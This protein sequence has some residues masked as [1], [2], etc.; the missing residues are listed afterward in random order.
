M[1]FTPE[2]RPTTTRIAVAGGALLAVTAVAVGGVLASNSH[3]SA[4]AAETPTEV[5]AEVAASPSATPD[6]RRA[7]IAAYGVYP[8]PVSASAIQEFNLNKTQIEQIA[9]AKTFAASEKAASVRAC[10]SGG[11]YKI[12]TGNGY[13]GA[14]QFD[15][16]TWQANGGGKFSE[17]ADLA[18]KWA[19]DYIA[20]KTQ[21]ASGWGPWA[22]A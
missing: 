3:D 18:P 21:Q 7:A 16:Q 6:Q 4:S 11:D 2:N 13:Y 1:K 22:C 15:L 8:L 5:S 10:E 17:T 14:Y 12:N 9:Q 20:F 19:Q